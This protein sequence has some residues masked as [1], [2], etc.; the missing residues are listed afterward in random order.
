M[1]VVHHGEEIEDSFRR[2]LGW[3]KQILVLARTLYVS[4]VL[5]FSMNVLFICILNANSSFTTFSFSFSGKC[6]RY[7]H[8]MQF[9]F[10]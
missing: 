3:G 5:F 1:C 9:S 2:N 7:I 8:C 6:V 10:V 4:V